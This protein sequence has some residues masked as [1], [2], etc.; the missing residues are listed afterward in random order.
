M[1][2]ALKEAVEQ[3][4]A[5]GFSHIK[6]E[7]EGDIGRDGSRDC[8]TCDGNG[9][10]ECDECNGRG[11]VS[12]GQFV[13]TNSEEVIEE[14]S[15]CYGDGMLDCDEC[16][17]AGTSSGMDE[18]DCQQFMRDYVT[19]EAL[20]HL[21][22][23]EF[24]EDGS[25][26]S[27][28]TFTIHIDHAEDVLQWI[29]AFNAL[30]DECNGSMDTS[31]AGMHITLLQGSRYPRTSG[32]IAGTGLRNFQT[33]VS[34]LLPALFFLA[35]SNYDS[36]GLDYRPASIGS[37]KYNAIS[38]HD[39]SCLEY[40]LFETCYTRPEVFFDYIKTIANTLKFYTDPNLKVQTLGKRFGFDYGDK[41]ARFY[42]T[43]EQLRIL[44]A[45][46]KHVKPKDK[47]I[48]QLKKE[49]GVFYSIKE[50]QQAEKQR[51]EDI[52]DDYRKL[53]ESFN[54]AVRAPLTDA[55]QADVDWYMSRDGYSRDRAIATVRSVNNLPT[56]GDF[57]RRNL[58]SVSYDTM[59]NV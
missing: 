34:K 22:Y 25:V 52:R 30:A 20:D 4:K 23:S 15:Q 46:I 51:L 39:D 49:R 38:T 42:N 56:L 36:R 6:V 32:E 10:E 19:R 35:S 13:G 21:I 27:E 1:K 26:D 18:S 53:R 40:R 55:E 43:P 2:G 45:T 33:E 11:A 24:Y 7:L 3:I 16:E 8:Y 41:V 29:A 31:G 58:R 48:K 50:L 44:N 14:C 57:I 47:T 37:G 59:I 5:A 12:T 17:G 28:F 54:E 9:R